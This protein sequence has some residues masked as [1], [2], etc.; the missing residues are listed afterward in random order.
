MMVMPSVIM[1]TDIYGDCGNHFYYTVVMQGVVMESHYAECR[2][3]ERRF[4]ERRYAERHYAERRYTECHG[5][6]LSK[7]PLVL[8]TRIS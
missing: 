3:A 8:A 2:Y 6:V 1:P 4:E 5:E 7:P